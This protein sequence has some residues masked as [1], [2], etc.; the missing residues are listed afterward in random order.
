M[1][2]SNYAFV[3]ELK[4]AKLN[5]FVHRTSRYFVYED[6][7]HVLKSRSQE[8]ACHFFKKEVCLG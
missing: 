6:E 2:K 5:F 3:D 4:I 8:F 1:N 7:N